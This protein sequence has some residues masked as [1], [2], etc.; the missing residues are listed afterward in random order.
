MEDKFRRKKKFRNNTINDND[1]V[2]NTNDERH[3][4]PIESKKKNNIFAKMK[5]YENANVLLL[6]NNL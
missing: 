1:R 2:N 4:T 6:Q 3:F 5:T